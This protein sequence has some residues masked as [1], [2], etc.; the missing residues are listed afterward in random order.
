MGTSI[1][2]AIDYLVAQLPSLVTAVD[3]TALVVDNYPAYVSDSMVFIGR[4]APGD[5]NAT[6]GSQTIVTL[7]ANKAE[8]SYN[9]PCYIS[10]YRPG[11]AQKPS[12][13]AAIALFD[14]VAHL[15][16]TDRTFGGILLQGR[17]AYID[18]FNIEQT[19]DSEE[20][21]ESGTLRTTWISFDI[22]A[23]NHYQA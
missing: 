1:G 10:V 7:G 14:V 19:L 6:T 3:P 18:H 4:T 22:T 21:G 11:P 17:Y 5:S 23:R 2:Q 12:R 8:E 16:A 15:V 20:A 9:I 13:D